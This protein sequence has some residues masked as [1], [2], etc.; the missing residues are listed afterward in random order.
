M[1]G[2]SS[3]L[4][5]ELQDWVD[6][7]AEQWRG[8][9]L[10]SAARGRLR[11]ELEDDVLTALGEGAPASVFLDEDPPDFARRV[12][13]AQ[14][15]PLAGPA[16]TVAMTPGR[17]ATTALA[18]AGAGALLWWLAAVPFLQYAVP[19]GASHAAFLVV[20]YGLG[21]VL[22]LTGLTVALR[23]RF[24]PLALL[25]TML[26]LVGGFAVGIVPSVLISTALGYPTDPILVVIVASPVLLAAWWGV[27]I[28]ARSSLRV[29]V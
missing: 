5:D 12:A 27:R 14:G 7:V 21:V 10:P 1:S 18:G 8:G 29:A 11:R 13:E 26:G 16:P 25:P 9:G 6:A 20:G 28:A 3:G 17:V 22:V 19:A 2:E 15:L 24:G 23:S 4:G